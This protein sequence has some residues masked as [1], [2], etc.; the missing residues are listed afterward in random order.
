[1]IVKMVN[2][3]SANNCQCNSWLDH[4]EAYGEER[5]I[6]CSEVFCDRMAV[7]GAQVQ[8]TREVDE[9]YYIVPVCFEH[10]TQSDEEVELLKGTALVLTAFGETCGVP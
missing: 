7:I 3:I 4:W 9:A 1:M 6:Y 8:K 2:A 5:A 10:S